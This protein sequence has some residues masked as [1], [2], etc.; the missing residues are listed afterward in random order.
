MG[1]LGLMC[2]RA[3]HMHRNHEGSNFMAA[4]VYDHDREEN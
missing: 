3:R 1:E 4:K 2:Y